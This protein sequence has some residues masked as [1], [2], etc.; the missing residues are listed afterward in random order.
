MRSQNQRLGPDPSGL[1]VGRAS[2]GSNRTAPHPALPRAAVDIAEI[3]GGPPTNCLQPSEPR[4]ACD[5]LSRATALVELRRARPG[6]PPRDVRTRSRLLR[7]FRA[8]AAGSDATVPSRPA[9]N[10]HTNQ[11]T[12]RP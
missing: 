10:R 5:V 11:A 2:G 7:G 3:G 8:R 6:S 4:L 9:A 1:A 12:V